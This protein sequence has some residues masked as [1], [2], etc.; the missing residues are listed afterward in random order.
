MYDWDDEY[1][2]GAAA[3]VAVFLAARRAKVPRSRANATR[4]TKAKRYVALR[5]HKRRTQVDPRP[6]AYD[7]EY[8]AVGGTGHFCSFYERTGILDAKAE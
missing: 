2:D 4:T 3:D 8:G 1:M 7:V 6:V 5:D